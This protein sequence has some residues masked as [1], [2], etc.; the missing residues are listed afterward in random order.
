M[1]IQDRLNLCLQSMKIDP[2]NRELKED[3][4]DVES[5]SF[6]EQ[7]DSS[8]LDKNK[9]SINDLDKNKDSINDLDKDKGSINDLEEEL[10]DEQDNLFNQDLSI[11]QKIILDEMIN[12]EVK[13]R[14]ALN[15]ELYMK[16]INK[17]FM[18]KENELKK[19][20]KEIEESK[21]II[22]EK[23]KLN[24]NLMIEY[25]LKEQEVK[26]K[27]IKL[28]EGQIKLKKDQE[29]IELNI[30]NERNKLTQEFNKL[31]KLRSYF[32]NNSENKYIKLNVGGKIF[33]TTQNLLKNHSDYFKGLLSGKFKV[34]KDDNNIIFIDR[35]PDLFKK[36][37][38]IIRDLDRGDIIEKEKEKEMT[39]TL[40]KELDY[41][42]IDC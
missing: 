30:I 33:E 4:L 14:I 24:K 9:G 22:D 18:Y 35:C 41:Y 5:K 25:Q 7:L 39:S 8:Y 40:I 10:D 6:H 36:I 27:Y 1:S 2:L 26:K 16:T 11:S 38:K 19:M 20:L 21:K 28:K 17:R 15:S 12:L 23:I 13:K 31:I 37:M 29:E 3:D 34:L 32:E 42:L